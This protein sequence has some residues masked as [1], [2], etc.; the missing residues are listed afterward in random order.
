MNVNLVGAAQD[1][2]SKE[3]LLNEYPRESFAKNLQGTC[4]AYNKHNDRFW[5]YY[6]EALR[7]LGGWWDGGRGEH[8][9]TLVC[10]WAL[11]HFTEVGSPGGRA[12]WGR[13]EEMR[14][15]RFWGFAETRE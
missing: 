7:T 4:L 10:R 11:L 6:R 14:K 13:N 8:R 15:S 12:G 9:R 2:L 1:G 5:A 3:C